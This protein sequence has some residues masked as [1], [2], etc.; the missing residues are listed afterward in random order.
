MYSTTLADRA[1]IRKE[2]LKLFNCVQIVCI[3]KEYLKPFNCVQMI[4]IWME[5]LI[6][7][8]YVKRKTLKKRHKKM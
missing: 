2:Y 4:C 1:C 7:Y 3:R 5:Y 6:S 8:N